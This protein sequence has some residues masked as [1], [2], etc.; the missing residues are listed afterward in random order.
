MIKR[1]RYSYQ[2]IVRYDTMVSCHQF[3]L[4]CTP[5][6]DSHQSVV[7]SEIQM[8]NSANVMSGVDSFG[9]TI[10]Y[11]SVMQRHDL[12]VVSSSGEVRCREYV[13]E[14]ANPAPYYKMQSGMT[15]L[16][17]PLRQWGER[18][19]SQGESIE[20][21]MELSEAIFQYMEYAPGVTTT[22]TTA[23]QSFSLRSGVCQ[24]YAHILIGLCRERGIMARYVVGLVVGTGETHAWVE[25]YCDGVWL[26]VDPTH[27]CRVEW[28]YIKLSHGRDANDCSV[29]R[30]IHRGACNHTTQVRVVVEEIL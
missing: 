30:G 12:F 1:Y 25:V 8:L 24:D 28:G 19:P 6:S 15:Q 3:L 10:H 5:M 7:E 18:V 9:A 14:E 26:G 21:V 29:T 13:I 16:S 23:S 20:E 2:T 4:R 17:E 22:L 27:N 11:G